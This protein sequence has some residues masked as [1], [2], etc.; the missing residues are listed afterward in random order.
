M[1]TKL[2]YRL[3]LYDRYL[4]DPVNPELNVWWDGVD[5][6]AQIALSEIHKRNKSSDQFETEAID[7]EE[8]KLSMV[9]EILNTPKLTPDSFKVKRERMLSLDKV[10]N[11]GLIKYDEE[12]QPVPADDRVNV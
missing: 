3:E 4:K 11:F 1:K 8:Q 7:F 10:E 9:D 2:D 5:K 6:S 12:G